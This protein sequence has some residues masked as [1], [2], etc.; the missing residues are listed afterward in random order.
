MSNW[1]CVSPCPWS[2]SC[3]SRRRRRMAA[4]ERA[5]DVVIVGGGSAGG[6]LPARLSENS[7]RNVVLLE[8]GP[9]YALDAYPAE[10]LNADI[11]ADPDHDWGYMARGNAAG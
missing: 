9:A 4:T 2:C 5:A 7:A 11:V 1:M 8:A 10:L 6:G 3:P